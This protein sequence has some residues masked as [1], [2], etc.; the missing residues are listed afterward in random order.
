MMAANKEAAEGEEG[1]KKKGKGKLIIILVVLLAL[2]LG[3]AGG[4]W[5]WWSQ[6]K[7]AAAAAAEDGDDE[8][9][10]PV[11]KKKKKKKEKGEEEKAPVFVSLDAFTVN[12]Q[13]EEGQLLQTTITLQMVDEEDAAKLKQHL[14]LIKSR[15]L[16]LLSSKH[17]QEVLTAEGKA[18]LA[19]EIAAQIRQPFFPGDY[20]MEILNVL[21][22]SFIVQ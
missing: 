1:A 20:P 2:I 9:Q 22:T 3:G 16:M 17:P 5:Y 4:G 18:K 6:K 12:L 19:E 21:F 8:D 11:K 7:A 15:L 10:A 14:P 13:G